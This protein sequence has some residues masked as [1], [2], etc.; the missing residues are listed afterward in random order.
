MKQPASFSLEDVNHLTNESEI[1]EEEQDG[2]PMSTNLE[3]KLGYS[4]SMGNT[5]TQSE[6]LNK[7]SVNWQ[8]V[9]SFGLDD[10]ETESIAPKKI[11]RKELLSHVPTETVV[12]KYGYVRT[13]LFLFFPFFTIDLRLHLG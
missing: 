12:M 9:K 4:V 2:S 11:R 10:L 8:S 6:T 13:A 1:V 7:E 5:I 3:E